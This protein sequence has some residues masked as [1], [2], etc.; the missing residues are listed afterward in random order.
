MHVIKFGANGAKQSLLPRQLLVCWVEFIHFYSPLGFQSSWISVQWTGMR[1][2]RQTPGWPC[3]RLTWGS[4]RT[5][6]F[7]GE[8]NAREA[9]N[10]LFHKHICVYLD[11]TV[12][13]VGMFTVPVSLA[14]VQSAAGPEGLVVVL[15]P[16]NEG[17]G[18][19]EG[20]EEPDE[21]SQSDGAAPLQLCPWQEWGQNIH[22]YCPLTPPPIW[23]Y[24][25]FSPGP[26]KVT[27]FSRRTLF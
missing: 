4:S 14:V 23:F 12:R 6:S 15:S 24:Y 8:K 7:C 17:H 9:R 21:H 25:I 1:T 10:A 2:W 27:H 18:G 16:A 26:V 5:R 22:Q 3:W 13:S 20:G 19:P 11:N